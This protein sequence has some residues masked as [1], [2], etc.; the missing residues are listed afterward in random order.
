VTRDPPEWCCSLDSAAI[1]RK[2]RYP[3]A[4]TAN[5]PQEPMRYPTDVL[6]PKPHTSEYDFVPAERP[7]IAEDNRIS[8]SFIA[9]DKV[10]FNTSD[11]LSTWL[12]RPRLVC[13]LRVFLANP[14]LTDN[15]SCVR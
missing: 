6:P 3:L 9:V 10:L 13:P 15:R 4:R 14:R 12:N 11:L 1:F 7:S 8:V 2:V 5:P